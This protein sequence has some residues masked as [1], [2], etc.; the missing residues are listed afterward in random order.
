MA[1]AALELYTRLP[2]AARNALRQLSG[3]AESEGTGEVV[4][5]VMRE[6]TR[7]IVGAKWELATR[8]LVEEV[9]TSG[10]LPRGRMSEDE[11]TD[12]AVSV[13]SGGGEPSVAGASGRVRTRRRRPARRPAKSSD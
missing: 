8:R 5:A 10:A 3:A 12:L 6:I 7:A 11:I 9:R 4:A 1:A 13:V 2:A